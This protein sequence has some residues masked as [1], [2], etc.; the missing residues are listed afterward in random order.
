MSSRMALTRT[1][2]ITANIV[3]NPSSRSMRGRP[4]RFRNDAYLARSELQLLD[5]TTL[6]PWVV[7]PKSFGGRTRRDDERDEQNRVTLAIVPRKQRF[8]VTFKEA[9]ARLVDG[10]VT[11]MVIESDGT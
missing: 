11:L 5:V 4:R 6:W 9:L 10:L 3:V 2:S 1:H 7:Y 8:V